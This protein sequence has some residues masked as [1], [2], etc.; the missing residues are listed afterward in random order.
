M[1]EINLDSRLQ[2][3]SVS[4]WIQIFHQGSLRWRDLKMWRTENKLQSKMDISILCGGDSID[5]G[6]Q[7]YFPYYCWYPDGGLSDEPAWQESEV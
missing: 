5:K 2:K 1:I 3:T 7:L 4:R 6:P